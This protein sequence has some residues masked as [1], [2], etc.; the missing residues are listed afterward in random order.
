MRGWFV[1]IVILLCSC[2][3]GCASR[4]RPVELRLAVLDSIGHNERM[5]VRLD[6]RVLYSGL[7]APPTWEPAI[8]FQ[9]NV[10]VPRAEHRLEVT[11]FGKTQEQRID[12]RGTTTVEIA[13][14]QGGAVIRLRDG[15][16][17]YI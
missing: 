16:I 15:K 11:V 7:V 1:S 4:E 14:R 2:G 13:L 8:V 10:V 6:G 9:M 3:F 17:I 5:T 12:A